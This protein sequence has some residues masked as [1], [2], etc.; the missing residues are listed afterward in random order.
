MS[1]KLN[2]NATLT[3]ACLGGSLHSARN[4]LGTVLSHVG[5]AC[6]ELRSVISMLAQHGISQALG[7]SAL[8]LHCVTNP[9]IPIS[10][11]THRMMWQ[12]FGGAEKGEV[13]H[14]DVLPTD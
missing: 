5:S 10:D 4:L 3:H 8:S 13:I 14:G 11:L 1:T 7:S 12:F 9:T 2:I 6:S